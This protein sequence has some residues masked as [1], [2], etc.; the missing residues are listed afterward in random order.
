MPLNLGAIGSFLQGAG[1]NLQAQQQQRQQQGQQSAVVR[2]LQEYANQQNQQRGATAPITPPMT[3][4]PSGATT[5]GA[6]AMPPAGG[7]APGASSGGF[8]GNLPPIDQMMSLLSK[9]GLSD[10]QQFEALQKYGAFASPIEK[11]TQQLTMAQEKM[12]MASQML[13]EKMKNAVLLQQM[14]G[15]TSSANTDK[16]VTA[17]ERGQDMGSADKGA[18]R[19]LRVKQMGSVELRNE[20][21]NLTSQINMETKPDQKEALKNQW[22]SLKGELDQRRAKQGLPPD[23]SKISADGAGAAAPGGEIPADAIAALKAAPATAAQFDE[24]FGPG[25]AKKALGQ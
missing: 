13:D 8:G 11:Y 3:P 14:R 1:P 4:A 5:A 17:Q 15:D 9:S 12:G 10:D 7:A 18:N 25:A 20:M 16:R 23:K 2:A 24:I 22:Q 6:Q 19:D 21:N